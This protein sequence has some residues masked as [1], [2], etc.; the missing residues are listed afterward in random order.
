MGTRLLRYPRNE[1][2]GCEM[3]P[4]AKRLRVVGLPNKGWN[5]DNDPASMPRCVACRTPLL[6]NL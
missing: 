2:S 6:L 4:T 1:N 3:D 5:F